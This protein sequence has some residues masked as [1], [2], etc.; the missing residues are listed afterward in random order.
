MLKGGFSDKFLTSN[1]DFGAN[2]LKK[3]PPVEDLLGFQKIKRH[4]GE[5]QATL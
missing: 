5:R 1:S 2:R 4:F 3:M